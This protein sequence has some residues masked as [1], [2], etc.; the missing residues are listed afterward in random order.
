MG[1][2]IR[3]RKVL[4]PSSS[5]R[6]PVFWM[7]WLK[8]VLSLGQDAVCGT[9]HLQFGEGIFA[10]LWFLWQRGSGGQGRAL[11]LHVLLLCSSVL[12]CHT[13]LPEF[14]SSI[15]F[16]PQTG[17]CV[18][19]SCGWQ[20]W[21]FSGW[22]RN[23]F[24][25]KKPLSHTVDTP[26]LFLPCLV[27]Y[28]RR[29]I[30]HSPLVLFEEKRKR[31]E[32][33]KRNRNTGESDGLNTDSISSVTDSAHV[34]CASRCLAYGLRENE[35]MLPADCISAKYRPTRPRLVIIWPW[36]LCLSGFHLQ[37]WCPLLWLCLCPDTFPQL[38]LSTGDPHPG[39]QEIPLLTSCH[40]LRSWATVLQC[41]S[42]WVWFCCVFG[43]G[44]PWSVWDSP[45]L[46]SHLMLQSPK[47]GER[48][49]AQPGVHNLFLHL[50]TPWLVLMRG[51]N[52]ST[53]GLPE[54]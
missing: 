44:M 27:L 36:R 47:P 14:S 45:L 13:L 42:P 12:A 28:R 33:L 37:F 50:R 8:A 32:T 16:W 1:A 5:T 35:Y 49:Q 54:S 2:K 15:E 19:H 20:H 48:A 26:H 39:P 3:A 23:S 9:G 53:K 4:W 22:W 6:A 41:F 17:F 7:L 18:Q 30:T 31:T 52:K 11:L 40:A 43:N 38:M 24:W 29:D 34:S 46:P 51:G 21:N 10:G 25:K